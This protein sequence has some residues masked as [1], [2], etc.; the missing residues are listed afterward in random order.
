[1]EQEIFKIKLK[2]MSKIYQNKP[3]FMNYSR[4]STLNQGEIWHLPDVT[5]K[6]YALILP[7]FGA[8]FIGSINY[9]VNL[10]LRIV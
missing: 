7:S 8:K 10:M 3:G 2:I 9:D 5:Q 6:I 4:P 1:M